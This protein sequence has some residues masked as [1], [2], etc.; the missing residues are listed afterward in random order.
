MIL[1]GFVISLSSTAVV[2]KMLDEWGE[3]DAKSGQ[4][5]ISIL[6]AQDTSRR[7]GDD[8]RILGCITSESLLRTHP[9]MGG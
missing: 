7:A 1:L 6:I 9:T 3:S 4:V 5:A 2:I 8:P